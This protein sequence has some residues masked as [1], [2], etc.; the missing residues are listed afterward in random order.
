MNFD[1]F[2]HCPRTIQI[3]RSERCLAKHPLRQTMNAAFVTIGQV[4]LLKFIKL[5]MTKS[6]KTKIALSIICWVFIVPTYAQIQ[7]FKIAIE[8]EG[9]TTDSLK[10]EIQLKKKPFKI[11]IDMPQ[12]LGLLINASF[13]STTWEMAKNGKVLKYMPGFQNT[14]MAD[15]NK[16]PNKEIL[17]SDDSPNYWFFDNKE[18]HR[19]DE[20][21]QNGNWLMCKREIERLFIV[22]N[23]SYVN[24]QDMHQPLYLVFITYDWVN[25][26]QDRLEKQRKWLK[27]DW[28]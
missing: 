9:L 4:C 24:I 17:I 5:K 26:F 19:F 11:I 20:V 3:E 6:F 10:S 8:Q 15:E 28:K 13:V 12:P 21:V 23:Q 25:D 1:K 22:E 27:I 18:S 16:N 2:V 14:G 7:R